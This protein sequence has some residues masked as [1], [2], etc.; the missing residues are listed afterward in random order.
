M[1][2]LYA[3]VGFRHSE[4]ICLDY[5]NEV[6]D[7]KDRLAFL[8]KPC[9]FDDHYTI[10]QVAEIEQSL[11]CFGIDLLPIDYRLSYTIQ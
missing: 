11:A 3:S 5:K 1:S 7:N 6:T 2:W 10:R 9:A 8:P 4:L